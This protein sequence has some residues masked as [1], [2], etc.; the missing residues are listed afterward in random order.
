M[1]TTKGLATLQQ[2]ERAGD[3]CWGGSEKGR[4]LKV[5]DE[6]LATVRRMHTEGATKS[7]MARATGLSRPTV[8]AL[9]GS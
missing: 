2:G 3:P 4:R 1:A 9:L 5:T 8:Y 7:A 6:Q